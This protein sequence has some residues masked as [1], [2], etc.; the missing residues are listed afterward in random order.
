MFFSSFSS[1]QCLP[2]TT[3]IAETASREKNNQLK[4]MWKTPGDIYIYICLHQ[5]LYLKI[6]YT[7]LLRNEGRRRSVRLFMLKKAE[8]TT[9]R[10]IVVCN[11]YVFFS[12][13]LIT[14]CVGSYSFWQFFILLLSLIWRTCIARRIVLDFECRVFIFK[15]TLIQWHLMKCTIIISKWSMLALRDIWFVFSILQLMNNV[16][17]K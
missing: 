1:L 8:A 11:N 16:W 4:P 14:L 15:N 13:S 5:T 2:P 10:S 3:A 6:Y 9:Q 12:F 7:F 17:N